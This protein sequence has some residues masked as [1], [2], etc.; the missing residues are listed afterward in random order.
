MNAEHMVDMTNPRVEAGLPFVEALARRMA[1]TMPH[2]IDLGDLVQDGVIGLIDAA[3]RFEESRGIKFETF[4]E[5]RVRGAM[6]DALRKDAW[7]R[8]VRRVRRELEAAREKLRATLGHEPSLADLAAEVGSDEQRLGKVIVRI[9]TIE[10]TSPLSCADHL[11]ESQLP[12]VMVP[13]EP[14]RPDTA[15]EKTE[16]RERVQRAMASLPARE[17]RV[18]SLYYYGEVTMKEIGAELGVNESRVSQLHARALRR[19]REALGPV[20]NAAASIEALRQAV[21]T[22]AHKPAMAKATLRPAEAA[23]APAAARQGAVVLD[24]AS[25][26]RAARSRSPRRNGFDNQRQPL[27]SRK[28]SAS[29]PATSPVTKITRRA[30]AGVVAAMAR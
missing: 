16:Q 30:S 5:R 21:I 15:Y 12:A 9:N 7:P 27:S 11:D 20:T 10:Q 18:I 13:T 4:A 26:S 17:R 3:R 8:G 29:V 24:Y 22:F 1:A 14:E 28:R 2:S 6:I 25:A 23:A 19:L